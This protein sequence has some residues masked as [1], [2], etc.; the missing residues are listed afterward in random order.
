M[1]INQ[2]P[3]ALDATFNESTNNLEVE[4]EPFD[5]NPVITIV[6]NPIA[7]AGDGGA[8]NPLPV[9]TTPRQTISIRAR[10]I[11]KRFGQ[12]INP[13]EFEVAIY[14]LKDD[15]NGARHMARIKSYLG[16]SLA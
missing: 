14:A 9:L 11:S 1:S 2:T 15:G 7:N 4:I 8:S 10:D 16:R 5:G 3:L 12:A 6:N 13:S